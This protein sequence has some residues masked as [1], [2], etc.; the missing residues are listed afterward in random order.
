VTETKSKTMEEG[1][2]R[3]GRRGGGGGG[4]SK[5]GK[6]QQRIGGTVARWGWAN[7]DLPKTVHLL[8]ISLPERCVKPR[9]VVAQNSV[10]YF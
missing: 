2:G 8:A 3:G 1:R 10:P 5:E 4:S 7:R 6:V 9:L